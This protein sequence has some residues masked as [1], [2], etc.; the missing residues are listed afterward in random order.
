MPL[1]ASPAVKPMPSTLSPASP[2]SAARR[3]KLAA[4]TCA[5]RSVMP[6]RCFSTSILC[7]MVTPKPARLRSLRMVAMTD[8]RSAGATCSGMAAA[9][10][11]RSEKWVLK[12]AV[13]RICATGSPR[14]NMIFVL[15]VIRSG[16][17][18]SDMK[19]SSDSRSAGDCDLEA[20]HAEGLGQM[21][22]RLAIGNQQMALL[23]AR[24]PCQGAMAELRGI[25]EH[26]DLSRAGNEGL[27]HLRILQ[28]IVVEARLG[29]AG[30]TQKQTIEVIGLRLPRCHRTD[31]RHLRR[32]ELAAQQID[33]TRPLG[34]GD[35]GGKAVGEDAQA[36]PRHQRLGQSERRGADIEREGLP[37]P[38]QTRGESRNAGLGLGILAPA[39]LEDGLLR[40]EDLVPA[41]LGPDRAAMGARQQPAGFERLEIA[42]DGHGGDPEQVG[43]VGDGDEALPPDNVGQARAPGA[44]RDTGSH[45]CRSGGRIRFR[46]RHL[47]HPR[48]LY[49]PT[50]S[51]CST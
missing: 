51:I 5:A 46:A 25:A 24:D 47:S 26:D 12:K 32:T 35:G 38:D 27:L 2:P 14:M 39:A 9:S 43:R 42:A 37:G 6:S 21:E 13:P 31:H 7:G 50:K 1:R 4:P 3:T 18:P 17:G 29:H 48:R 28:G 30:N 19:D 41:H 34:E 20:G 16:T 10:S 44:G 36:R 11:P 22:R 8:A 45:P 33:G 40:I 23:E 15:P 49:Y